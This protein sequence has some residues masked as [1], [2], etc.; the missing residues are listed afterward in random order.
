[1]K[2]TSYRSKAA[3]DLITNLVRV[4][5]PQRA[6]EIGTQQGHSALL[7]CKGMSKN[8]T[9]STY[10]LF[11]DSYQGPPYLQTHAN[12]EIACQYLSEENPNC[13]WSVFVGDHKTALEHLGAENPIDLLHVDIC[14]HKENLRP[15]LFDMHKKVTNMILLEGG[16]YN[17]WHKKYG[18]KPYTTMLY[19]SW[20]DEW[21]HATLQINETDALTIM[22]RRSEWPR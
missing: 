21:N 18:Y 19:E 12:K 2:T 5:D 22:T 10:D 9:F 17:H 4:V 7:I 14:N 11:E 13:F 6:V 1:M 15:I 8:S 16:H 3:Q 20:L